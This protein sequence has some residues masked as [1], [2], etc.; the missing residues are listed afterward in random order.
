LPMHVVIDVL[1]FPQIHNL[2]FIGFY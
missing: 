1:F 2:N